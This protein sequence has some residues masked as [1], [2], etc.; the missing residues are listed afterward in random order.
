MRRPFPAFTQKQLQPE[1]PAEGE[2]SRASAIAGS[3][4]T[5]ARGY[6]PAPGGT[7]IATPAAR[8]CWVG[9]PTLRPPPVCRP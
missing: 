1:T 6:L 2:A 8:F 3:R 9:M 7:Q 5:L 4:R